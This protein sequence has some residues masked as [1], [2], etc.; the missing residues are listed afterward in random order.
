MVKTLVDIMFTDLV[1][2]MNLGV[3]KEIWWFS[4]CVVDLLNGGSVG[5]GSK[6]AGKCFGSFSGE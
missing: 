5:S 4:V 3:L 2:F 6:G 1:F